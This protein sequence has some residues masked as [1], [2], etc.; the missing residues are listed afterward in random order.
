MWNVVLSYLKSRWLLFVVL[1]VFVSFKLSQLH[2]PFYLDEAWVY[3]PAVKMMAIHGPGLLPG[4][5][6]PDFSRG[7]PLMFHF[8]AS[9]WIRCFGTSNI[10]VHSFPLFL[11]VIF[12]VSLYECCLRLFG[13]REASL[14]LLLISGSVIFFVQSS[15]VYPE[16]MLALFT[17]LSLY[18]YSKERLLLTSLSLF[19]LFFTKEGGL[20][21]GAVIGIDATA[22][23][24]RR[25]ETIWRKLQRI[26]SVLV[27]ACLIGCFLLLQKAKL[28]W[29]ILPEHSNM[30]QTNWNY[31][32]FMFKRGIYWAYRGETATC[33]MALFILLMS[34]VPAIKNKNALYL[35]LIPPVVIV[36]QM[37]E[38]YATNPAGSRFW[39][40]L[41]LLSFVIPVYCLIR[42]NKDR[43]LPERK[44]IILAAICVAT[45]LFY[46]S[47]TQIGYRYLLVIL[48]LIMIFQ[49]VSITLFADAGDRR[50]YYVAA[51]GILIINAYGFYSNERVEDTQMGAFQVMNVQL[52]EFAF[53]E[54]ENA[55]DEEIA[56]GCTWESYRMVD[57][58]QGFLSSGRIFTHLKRFP[59]GPHTDYA[60]FGNSCGDEADYRSILTNPDFHLV[61]KMRDGNIWAEIYKHN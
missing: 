19:M 26:L 21:F 23:L 32:Y 46:S 11:A 43:K 12:L 50:I 17:F 22:C 48:V 27:P 14:A 36:Y 60:M 1:L 2:Y 3:A 25:T 54:K 39:V 4:A 51:A 40:L 29:Y 37:A 15:F 34:V 38:L 53:L 8:L 6:P 9:I 20:V 7:H 42:L 10:S 35:F 13:R 24:F 52:K 41:Y 58:V 31:Y 59:V 5:L 45:Y 56:Y 61:F 57:T 44:F 18:F 16:I 47:L 30:I 33:I 28:G 49:A 55:Y